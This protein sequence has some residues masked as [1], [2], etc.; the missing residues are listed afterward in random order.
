MNE[1]TT[2][3]D[4]SI[5]C[6]AECGVSYFDGDDWVITNGPIA[7]KYC[8][9]C[10]ARLYPNG[11]SGPSAE[12]FKEWL[13]RVHLNTKKLGEVAVSTYTKRFRDGQVAQMEAVADKLGIDM[14]EETDEPDSD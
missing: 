8:R 14:E 13:A 3:A 4:G 11:T 7:G 6:S 1:R 12:E 2:D 10:G 5:I 9:E